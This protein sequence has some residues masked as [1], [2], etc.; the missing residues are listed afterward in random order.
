MAQKWLGALALSLTLAATGS[1]AAGDT[2]AEDA[3]SAEHSTSEVGTVDLAA[4]TPQQDPVQDAAVEE[5]QFGPVTHLPMPRYVSMKAS[6]GNV[7]RGPSVTH[8]IDWVFMR[9]NMPMQIIAEFGH[10]RRVVD[11]EGVGGWIHHSLLSGVRTVLVQKDMLDI[12]T[13]PNDKSPVTAQLELGVI[14]R[15][16]QCTLDW[17]RVSVAGYK[18]WAPKSAVWGVDPD[19]VRD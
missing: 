15:L 5:P 8:R 4:M 14:A 6:K 13:R 3:A 19:E 11:Q 2:G 16:H 9:R 7:R 1:F 10:W 18:G 12:H 17:C